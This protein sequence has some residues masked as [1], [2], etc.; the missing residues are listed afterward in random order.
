[1][2]MK[3]KVF[4]NLIRLTTVIMRMKKSK[5]IVTKCYELLVELS[6]ETAEQRLVLVDRRCLLLAAAG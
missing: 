4:F 6:E 5:E 2:V 3:G 1:M